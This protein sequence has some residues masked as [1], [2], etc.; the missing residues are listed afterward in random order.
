MKILI[1][2]DQGFKNLFPLTMLRPTYDLRIGANT[3]LQRIES[4]VKDKS[5]VVL[6][7]RNSLL[8]YMREVHKNKINEIT[9]D[10]YLL[11]NG[12]VIFTADTLKYLLSKKEKNTS[13]YLN[14]ELTAASITKDKIVILAEMIENNLL[15]DELFDSLKHR[16]VFLDKDFHLTIIKYPWDIINYVLQGG[17]SEDLQYFTKNNNS[18]KFK[19]R[20][21]FIN[22]KKISISESVNIY[23]E[24]VLDASDGVI[25]IKENTIIEPFTFI[26]G[27]VYIG[28]NCLIKSGTKI[29]GP[30]VIGEYSRAS[31]EIAE[32]VFH[33]YV[34]KQHDGFVGHSYICPFVNLGADTVTSDLKNN[35]SKVRMM[36]DKNNVDTDMQLLGSI[37]GDHSKTSV[38]TML[39][40]GSSIGIF[41][42]LFGGGFHSKEIDNFSWNEAGKKSERFNIDKAIETAK[43]VMYRRGIKMSKAYELMVRNYSNKE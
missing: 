8:A 19:V 24:V 9:K 36:S 15:P 41:S 35:Y 27:P 23:P 33:S 25:M 5:D 37:I 40:T 20:D 3:I 17:L 6:H 42:N 10:D 1:F 14:N 22:P 11:L 34:N 26:K 30:C 21:N 31:G 18:A 28:K 13:Y 38:N 32:S 7:C 2:E 12:R 29:Y 4:I 43:I 39:N 16:K